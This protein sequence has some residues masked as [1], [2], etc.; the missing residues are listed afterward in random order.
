MSQY[1]LYVVAVILCMGCTSS[2]PL[3]R[4][5]ERL[6]LAPCRVE[7]LE[8]KVLCG[9]YEVWEDRAARQGRKI[10]LHVVVI[11]SRAEPPEPDP[12]FHFAGGPGGAVTNWVRWSVDSPL[13]ERRDLVFIDQRGTGRSNPLPCDL[14]PEDDGRERG[15]LREIFPVARLEACRAELERHADLTLYTSELAM[16]DYDEVREWLGYGKINLTG[17]SY[18][19]RTVQVYMQ[20]HPETVRA[21][22]ASAIHD[23]RRS[24][25]R[26]Q[27]ANA[28]A[29][30]VALFDA[31]A[32]EAECG[33]AFPRLPAELD[34]LLARLAEE[35]AVV[36]IVDPADGQPR[37]LRLH[38]DY[39]AE[40]LRVSLYYLSFSR[41]LPM[42]IHLA[43]QGDYEPLTQ[44]GLL[45]DKSYSG[46]SYGMMLSVY[47]SEDMPAFDPDE[48][49]AEAER[50]VFG[51]YRIRQQIQ[52]CEHWPS[53]RLPAS[54]Y[55]PRRLDVPT[56]FIS[57]AHDP[58]NTAQYGEQAI[59][60]LPNG[61][62]LVVA[63]AHHG[64]G[65]LENQAC[66]WQLEQE[67]LERGSVEGLDTSCIASMRR[68]PFFTERGALD[69]YI[70]EVLGGS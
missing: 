32:A 1:R 63:D 24:P 28:Q 35:P 43:H 4:A 9:T 11:P 10:P 69:K 2:S 26:D 21:A 50:T 54:F 58:V 31:C 18:G 29:T 42:A 3:R 41:A 48:A 61:L 6:P 23:L 62:H 34:E 25:L 70:S 67:F 47:C 38:R 20:R 65:G 44:I 33:S 36:E 27:A 37:R 7:G 57:G 59:S 40:R 56:L 12:I 46:V 49:V 45:F 13:R 22:F 5:A 60:D 15:E 51:S 39:V 19:S 17:G 68:K 14:R 55:T 52:A 64:F 30:L 16:D 8:E 66:A 53:R